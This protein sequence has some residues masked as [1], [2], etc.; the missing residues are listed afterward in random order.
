MYIPYTEQRSIPHL[1]QEAPSALNLELSMHHTTPS[2]MKRAQK[3]H[4][5]ATTPSMTK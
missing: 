1:I 5:P 3:V 4:I 2:S